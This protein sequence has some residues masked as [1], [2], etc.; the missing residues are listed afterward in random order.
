[1]RF[2]Q[3]ERITQSEQQRPSREW[4]AVSRTS[5]HGS[6]KAAPH[7]KRLGRQNR[8]LSPE[9]SAGPEWYTA[10]LDI[11]GAS[12]TPSAIR[13]L[14]SG[15]H[16]I[17]PGLKTSVL[18]V[19]G[20]FIDYDPSPI[21]VV[22]FLDRQIVQQGPPRAMLRD[23]PSPDAQS[24]GR[25]SR[26]SRIQSITK[27]FMEAISPLPGPIVPPLC[28]AG[29]SGS[30]LRMTSTPS[31]P[32][33][34]PDVIPVSLIR[35]NAPTFWIKSACFRRRRIVWTRSDGYLKSDRRKYFVPCV[36]AGFGYCLRSGQVA[37]SGPSK[38]A[39]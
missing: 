2:Y 25:K 32:L 6:P 38:S 7:G 27:S 11:S 13:R 9:A 1:M 24:R 23:T 22:E 19:I 5:K 28:A 30:P 12:W 17:G 8:V 15:G 35:R 3:I 10:E 21:M 26:D 37:G 18:N 29:Q 39:V 16:V 4:Q 31:R 33:P 34:G 20:F 14:K 36:R